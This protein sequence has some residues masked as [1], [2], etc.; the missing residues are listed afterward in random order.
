[1]A[2][3]MHEWIVTHLEKLGKERSIPLNTTP[4]K[5]I[6]YARERFG[7]RVIDQGKSG[8]GHHWV[9]RVCKACGR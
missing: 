5:I 2:E 7:W 8:D 1:M 6:S 4:G 3:T 9:K